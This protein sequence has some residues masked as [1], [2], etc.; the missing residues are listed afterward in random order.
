MD[1]MIDILKYKEV[2]KKILKTMS[3]LVSNIFRFNKLD[4]SILK[5]GIYIAT[6]GFASNDPSILSDCLWAL[7][8]ISGCDSKE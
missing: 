4:F 8:Y 7:S 6:A 1:I 5:K 2:S 3:W